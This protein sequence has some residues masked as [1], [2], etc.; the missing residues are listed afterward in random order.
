MTYPS[1]YSRSYWKS[2][3]H[4]TTYRLCLMGILC[5]V[6]IILSRI[7]AISVGNW[8]RISFGFLPNALAG[9]LLGPVLGTLVA[10]VSDALG[11][12]FTGQSINPGLSLAVALGGVLYGLFLYKRPVKLTRIALCLLAV[13]LVCHFLLNTYFLALAGF[14]SVSDGT[15][16][17]ALARQLVLPVYHAGAVMPTWISV[18]NRFIKQLAVYPVNVVMLYAVLR[19]VNKL[20]ASVWKR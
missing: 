20:P 8:L 14:T 18:C 2:S 17:P 16:W 6:Q 7:T 4:I 11:V 19:S 13:S 15:D 5:A 3:A 9:F 12:I 10:V 1:L